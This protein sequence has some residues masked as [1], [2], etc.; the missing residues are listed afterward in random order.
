MV[1]RHELTHAFNLTQTGFLVPIWLTEGLAVRAERT[2]RFD[3]VANHLR[4][5]MAAGTAFDLDSIGRGYH[6]FGNPRD[7]LLAYHQG[8]LYVQY[9]AAT[10]GAEAIPKLLEAFR[11][12]LDVND[13]IRRACGVEKLAFEKGYRDY[14]RGL[15]KAAPRAEKPMTFG[16]LE[17]AHKKDPED[18]DIA[19]R[20]AGE[21]HTS[22]QT[23]GSPQARRCRPRKGEGPPGGLA[24]E[25]PPPP[26]R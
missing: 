2:Q 23:G 11:Q 16:E 1:A 26:A 19:A 15:V 14:V 6:N 25:G 10:H 20:L 24:R 13:A 17:A 8:F 21:V 5:R 9:I 18:L 4:D 22:W 12:G 3:S 7:V